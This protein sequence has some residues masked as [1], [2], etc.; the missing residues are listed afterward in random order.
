VIEEGGMLSYFLPQKPEFPPG[1]IEM[2]CPGCKQE[3]T[4]QR[5]DLS[6]QA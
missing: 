1:G 3:A 6:Y 5:S 4:Y 2:E